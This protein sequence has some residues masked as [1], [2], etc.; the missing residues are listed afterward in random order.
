MA[1]SFFVFG[2]FIFIIPIFSIQVEQALDIHYR[3]MLERAT[4][5]A[6]LSSYEASDANLAIETFKDVFLMSSPEGFEYTVELKSF[7]QYPKMIHFKVY[8]KNNEGFEYELEESLIEED[9]NGD[10][11]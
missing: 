1:V 8:A 5:S 6:I 2:L 7:E 10:Y 9:L 3:Y 4:Q 11:S